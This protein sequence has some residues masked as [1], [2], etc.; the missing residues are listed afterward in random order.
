MVDKN[1]LLD[2]MRFKM[3][4][5]I[6]RGDVMTLEEM[7]FF[8]E[9]TL[10]ICGS[11]DIDTVL[12]RC[13]SYLKGFFPLNTMLMCI[14]KPETGTVHTIAMETDSD[15][16]RIE[17]PIQLS[18][19]ARR[20]IERIFAVVPDSD[21]RAGAKSAIFNVPVGGTIANRYN[22]VTI[23]KDI[24]QDI[25]GR[26]VLPALGLSRG[27]D[28]VLHLKMEGEMLGAVVVTADGID[29]YQPAQAR[30]YGLLHDPFAIA[31][32]NAFRYREM[33]QLKD[34]LKED[35]RYLH[36][37][38]HRISGEDI[39]GE[40]F[41][42]AD[43]MDMVHQVAPLDSH[44]LLLGE[45][46]VGKEVVANAVHY[47][48]PRRNGPLIKVNCG[49]IP[50]MLLDSELFGHERGAFTGAIARKR[51]RFERADTGTIFLDEIG[52]LP[53]AAQVRLLRV[54]QTREIERVGGSQSVPVN[55]RIIAATHRDLAAMARTGEFREDLWFRLNVFPITIPPL[56]H[57]KADIPALVNHFIERKAREMKLRYQPVPAPG[58]LERL[59]G[60]D[61]P[62]NVRELENIVERELI[63][64]Q[65]FGSNQPLPFID[66]AVPSML[67]PS[68]A[69]S[70]ETENSL[71]L[72]MVD[73]AHIGCVLQICGGKVQGKDGAAAILGLHPSTLRNKM[74]KLGVV[75]GRERKVNCCDY[76]E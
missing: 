25:V 48:S 8:Y 63:R 9:A 55:I 12:G 67:S 43:V 28:M 66:V 21:I 60:Y 42:L 65:R 50:E 57:R 7:R 19:A 47:A 31:M 39:I 20:E 51:G 15:V 76:Q 18:G 72:D 26:E 54:M 33:R 74:R 36:H 13:F 10:L 3:S 41:G 24:S 52:E 53:F 1:V 40:K 70:P 49:A 5:K 68:P 44:V 11:L 75:F 30:L 45:T 29:R 16:R 69:I 37:E 58:A 62:G 32:S 17:E 61:W 34:L 6:V 38:L 73:R 59:Q 64:S 35:N 2:R 46:G 71:T 23:H 27:S 22:K 14:Y 56:R 4:Y